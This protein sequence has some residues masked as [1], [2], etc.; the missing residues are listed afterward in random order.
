MRVLELQKPRTTRDR[1]LP[2]VVA[3]LGTLS[4]LLLSA[5]AAGLR[6]N[7][8]ASIP[9]GLY[10]IVGDAAN[11]RRGDVVLA[12]L[13]REIAT[14]AHARGYVPR[15][16]GCSDAMAPI[17]KLVMALPGDTVVVTETG[18][19]VN[20]AAVAN[21]RRLE[22]DGAG[23]HLEAQAAGKYMVAPRTL[24]LVGSS[25]RSFDSRYFGAVGS[26]SVL[27]QLKRGW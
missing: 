18:L 26:A 16:S 25:A 24:W 11:L 20:G 15:G 23:R 17:G 21:S 3:A 9:I 14:L 7:L 2:S 4:I 1:L 13:P 6:L 10:H 19:N 8:S 5:Y 22:R 12:C 27:A